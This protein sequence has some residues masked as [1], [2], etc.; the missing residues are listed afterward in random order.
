M[1]TRARVFC[2]EAALY[3]R[4]V[5]ETAPTPS[6]APTP[7][8]RVDRLAAGALTAAAIAA[9]TCMPFLALLGGT[10]GLV[11]R[12]RA[13]AEGRSARLATSAIVVAAVSVAM[14]WA[15]WDL[16]TRW[17][18]PSMQRRMTAA[19]T[20]ACEGRWQDAV[21][22]EPGFGFA[23]ALPAP[24]EAATDRFARSLRE[25]RGGL[26]SVSLVSQEITGSP[27]SPTVTAA[28]VLEF[29]TGSATGS[30]S[31]QWLPAATETE[32]Q[33]LPSVRLLTLEVSL[34]ADETL[35]LAP[36]A[37]PTTSEAPTP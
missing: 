5:D 33:W 8:A 27:M 16:S 29:E 22:A 4:G 28:L 18:M 9:V 26:R 2:F 34:P 15:L 12:R 10:L 20:A 17:L 36:E 35:R 13:R 23:Q 14:Q 7:R 30:A 3:A 1:L 31:M 19:I 37:G 11:A 32:A 25:R 21:P 24:D 6:P